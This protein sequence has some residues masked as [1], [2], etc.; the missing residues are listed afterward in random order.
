MARTHI[1]RFFSRLA[2]Q[3][4]RRRE[5]TRPDVSAST[6]RQKAIALKDYAI[7]NNFFVPDDILVA[8]NDDAVNATNLDKAIRD[9]TRITYPTTIETIS[10]QVAELP[11]LSKFFTLSLVPI[12][13][14]SLGGAIYLSILNDPQWWASPL[15]ALLGLMGAIVNMLFNII[16]IISE[17][18]FNSRDNSMNLIRI[19]LGPVLGWVLFFGLESTNTVEPSERRWAVVLLPFLAGFSIRL[20]VGVITQALRTIELVLGIENKDTELLRRRRGGMG[21]S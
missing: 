15:A 10:F 12:L 9:L 13:L 4:S 2:R 21:G 8:L 18:A 20:V 3:A 6:K 17:K 1:F 14:L 11:W 19:A 7:E 5:G 16:G